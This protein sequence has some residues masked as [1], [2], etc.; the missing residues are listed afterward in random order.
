M[1]ID[2][3]RR[4]RAGMALLL[5]ASTVLGFVNTESPVA[6]VDGR[7]IAFGAFAQPQGSQTLQQSVAQLETQIGRNLE[8]VR[9]FESWSDVFP[10]SFHNFLKAGDRTIILSVRPTRSN[11]TRVLWSAIANAAP[12]SQVDTE[13]RTWARRIRDFD[14]PIYITLHHEPETVAN[15][16]FGTPT[17]FISAWRHWVDVFRQE[18][19]SN[20]KFMWIM[21]DYSYHV[22]TSDRRSAPTW[23][24][25]DDWVD[26]MAIDAYNWHTCRPNEDNPWKTL[27]TIIEPFRQFGALHPT[28]DLWLTEW[29]SWEDPAVTNRKAGWID[30]A[31]ALFKG[32]AYSQFAGVLYFH[33]NAINASFVDC[34]WRADTSASSLAS[35]RAM[36]QDPFYQGD[37][38]GEPAIA[39]PTFRASSS[40]NGTTASAS[41]VVPSTVI[42]GDRLVLIITANAATTATT[43]AGWTLL[44]TQSDGTPD[45][46]SWVFT[47][48]AAGDTGGSTVSSTLGASGKS[49]RILLAYTSSDTPT[50]VSDIAGPSTTAHSTPATTASAS[51][52][53]IS[54]WSDKTNDNTAWTLPAAVQLRESSVGTGTGHIT[55]AAGDARSTNGSQPA[56][57]AVSTAASAKAIMWTIGLPALAPATP[58]TFVAQS[59]SNA[60]AMSHQVSVPAAVQ[61]GDGLILALTVN[62]NATVST[63]AGITGWRLLAAESNGSMSTHV[64]TRVASSG[65]AGSAITIAMS[66]QAKG[67]L[68]LSAY[69]GTSPVDPVVSFDGSLEVVSRADH[70]TPSIQVSDN[71]SWV[72]WYWA[73]ED[74]VTNALVPPAGVTVRASGTQ[75]GSGRVTGLLA[76][77]DGPAAVGTVPGRTA[78]AAAPTINATM[79]AIVL[80]PA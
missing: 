57:S 16:A 1:A 65:D 74:A 7:P 52:T 78:T 54:Y 31:R 61:P 50:A 45:M 66:Q 56:Q 11:G 43:P 75:T 48:T 32:P 64:W 68:V 25:G 72:V 40:A 20:A 14:A 80:A 19:A 26:A 67:N 34:R 41:V 13:V 22:P 30:E 49:S 38:I 24:P 6:A 69:R 44:G 15:S 36:A 33:S 37:A 9:V 23:Y 55:A 73:H 77:S 58:I 62:N 29:A 63:P 28:K 21:T 42:G 71:R 79:W 47:R 12:G 76:D 3:R 5:A 2:R 4:V 59:S 51:S 53:L 18:G 60:N 35:F 17:E 46:R 39:G 10:D 27:A 8:T 70:T